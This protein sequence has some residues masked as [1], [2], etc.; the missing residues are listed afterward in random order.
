MVC[1]IKGC[2]K[3]SVNSEFCEYHYA[4]IYS[5]KGAKRG[6]RKPK[7]PKPVAMVVPE[8]VVKVAPPTNSIYS[9]F[10]PVNSVI[11][12]IPKIGTF[13]E[14]EFEASLAKE[15]NSAAGQEIRN[16]RKCGKV[17]IERLRH[18]RTCEPH[19]SSLFHS[20]GNWVYS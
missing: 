3:P 5:T 19:H 14:E 13:E 16:C 6:D 2:S 8:P 7:K 10:L 18:C 11:K 9:K 4:C 17:I 20:D 1:S 15:K 12:E